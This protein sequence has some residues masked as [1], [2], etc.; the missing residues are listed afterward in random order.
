MLQQKAKGFRLS[1]VAAH[2]F[3]PAA[4]QSSAETQRY[5]ILMRYLIMTVAM[6]LLSKNKIFSFSE[7]R[8]LYGRLFPTATLDYTVYGVLK[9]IAFQKFI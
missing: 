8:L 3:F 9:G 1:K 7:C 6:H 5:R 2:L 4:V